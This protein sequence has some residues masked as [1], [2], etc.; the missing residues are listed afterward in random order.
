[1]IQLGFGS[2]GFR[3]EGKTGVPG[4]K[5]LGARTRTNNKLNPP[6]TLG[7]GVE[8]GPH[9]ELEI[10]AVG[11][12]PADDISRGLR[13]GELNMGHRYNNGPEF[14]YKSAELWPENKVNAPLEKDDE[15]EKKKKR[16]AGASHE[17][18][19]IL[20]WKKY[21][22]L[23]K[24]RR[25]TAYVMPFTHNTRVSEQERLMGPLA[26]T[27]LR[28]AQNYLV[29]RAQV[30]SFGEEIECLKRGQEI[31]KQSRIKSLDPRMED[32]FLVVVGRLGKAQ[33]LPYKMRYPRIIDSHDKLAQQVIEEMHRT[34]T[35][36]NLALVE[37]D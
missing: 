7:P 5:P 10:C 9:C 33:S 12:H 3:R 34:Y 15:R 13:P 31:R 6:M 23:G 26:S 20:G 24:L 22:S 2:V 21:S 19:V 17:I 8:P 37:P 14:L 30:E 4:E 18:D 27:E 32:G 11:V 36:A 25:V 1:M 29:K 28:A 16:W 35:S